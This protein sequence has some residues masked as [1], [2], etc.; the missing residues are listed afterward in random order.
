MLR[1]DTT[2]EDWT[3]ILGGTSLAYEEHNILSGLEL[4]LQLFEAG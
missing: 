4:V 1:K 2:Q 3:Y